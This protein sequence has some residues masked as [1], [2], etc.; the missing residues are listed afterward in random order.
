MTTTE[1][2]TLLKK[3]EYGGAT[4]RPREISFDY[5]GLII[6]T[7]NIEV[8]STGDGLITEICFSLKE[9]GE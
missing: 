6:S 9:D 8:E 3:Y 4:G 2:I 7:P 5:N 1:L